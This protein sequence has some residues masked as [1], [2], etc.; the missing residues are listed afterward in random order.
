MIHARSWSMATELTSHARAG[1][2]KGSSDGSAGVP[3]P[4][5][6]TTAVDANPSA[7]ASAARVEKDESTIKDAGE[8]SETIQCSLDDGVPGLSGTATA[9]AYRIA[10]KAATKSVE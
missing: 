2:V 10:Q 3:E 4:P 1:P 5:T 6:Q 9:P 7:R 8:Q